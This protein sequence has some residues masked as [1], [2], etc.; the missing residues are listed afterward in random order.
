[1]VESVSVVILSRIILGHNGICRQI[2]KQASVFAYYLFNDLIQFLFSYDF[3]DYKE[4]SD[5]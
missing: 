2:Q 3:T 1:M 4:C 5:M